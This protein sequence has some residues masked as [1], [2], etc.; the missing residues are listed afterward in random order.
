MNV[1]MSPA[2]PGP[3]P[4]GSPRSNARVIAVVLAGLAVIGGLIALTSIGGDG[5]S[6]STTDRQLTPNLAGD[7]TTTSEPGDTTPTSTDN[8]PINDA[9]DLLV[10]PETSDLARATVM[11]LQLDSE[12]IPICFSGSG[13]VVSSTGQILTNAHVVWNDP[14]C[15]YD[16]LGVAVVDAIDEPPILMYL[17]DVVAIDDF[18]DLAVV[19]IST[20]I[21][22]DQ[23]GELALP[24]IALG[25]SSSVELGDSLRILGFPGIGGDTITFTRGAV[26]GFIAERGVDDTRAWIKTDATIAG[27]NSGGVAAN[28]AGELVGVPTTAGAGDAA[29]TDCRVIEDTNGDGFIDDTDSCI[30]IGGFINGLRPINLASALIADAIDADSIRPVSPQISPTTDFNTDDVVIHDV[31]FSPD[32]NDDDRPTEVVIAL[33]SGATKVCAFWTY[34]GMQDGVSYDAIW[35][36]DGEADTDASFLDDVWA[37]GESGEWWVCVVN[38]N[39]VAD[40]LYEFEFT[41]DGEFLASESIFVGGDRRPVSITLDNQTTDRICYVQISPTLSGYW[42]TDELG[43]TEVIE[44]FSSRVFDELVTGRYDMVIRD[45]DLEPINQ[46]SG[47]DLS[48]DETLIHVG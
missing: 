4:P 15:S 33:P 5:G 26:S 29:T 8:Q 43:E 37:G 36:F 40:G 30:P 14:T 17:A 7:V 9:A 38:D 18:L 6:D 35:R 34:T 22:G 13:S 24:Y 19:Q 47:L 23:L 1:P 27:G 31:Y 28:E 44:P 48:A 21:D 32:V 39:G 3:P 41:V 12:G 20:D 10:G 2:P 25:D 45:C 46:W 11:L 16:L 42:G